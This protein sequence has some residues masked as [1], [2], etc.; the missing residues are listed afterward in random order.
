MPCSS[1]APARTTSRSA[2]TGRPSSG[3]SQALG[4]SRLRARGILSTQKSRPSLSRRS[5]ARWNDCPPIAVRTLPAVRPIFTSGE[6]A[7]ARDLAPASPA[8]ARALEMTTHTPDAAA[9]L[10]PRSCCVSAHATL[11]PSGPLAKE[12]SGEPAPG[13]PLT[14]VELA[15]RPHPVPQAPDQALQRRKASAD[16]RSRN[17]SHR[18]H[19]LRLWDEQ[20][21]PHRQEGRGDLLR[22]A[23]STEHQDQPVR[24]PA[25]A[26][27]GAVECRLVSHL[28]T[29]LPNA[30]PCA[31]RAPCAR[32]SAAML[33]SRP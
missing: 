29:F 14:E 23:Q 2:N 15:L 5:R 9:R 6:A 4:S 28:C 13:R 21:P 27:P 17:R 22:G 19:C 11:P 20:V 26:A 24:A 30:L 1:A 33:L 16:S 8:S 7:S 31:S 25:G 10:N 12:R 18:L 32:S 3:C